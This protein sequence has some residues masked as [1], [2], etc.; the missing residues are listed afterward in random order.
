[1][2]T[3]PV[4]WISAVALVACS[5]PTLPLS[6][7]KCLLRLSALVWCLR[8]LRVAAAPDPR[9]KRA[10]ACEPHALL[11]PLLHSCVCIAEGCGARKFSHGVPEVK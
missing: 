6:M 11:R 2:R 8:R 10:L 7:R 1:M 9:L 3:P 4:S 5:R